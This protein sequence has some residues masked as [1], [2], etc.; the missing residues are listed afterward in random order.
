[1]ELCL[2]EG[3]VGQL[4]LVFRNE[5]GRKGAAEGV[6][7]D[8]VILGRAEEQADAGVFMLL[9]DIAVEGF[10]VEVELTEVRGFEASDLEL[11]GDEGIEFAMVEE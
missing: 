8:L 1:M 7:D 11:D 9:A 10:E 5:G 6:F 2:K 3:F 4:G